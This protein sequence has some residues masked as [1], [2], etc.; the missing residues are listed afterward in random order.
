VGVKMTNAPIY[1]L[2]FN[3][4]IENIVD[5]YITHDSD[6]LTPNLHQTQ[7][8]QHKKEPYEN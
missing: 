6:K 4:A 7:T 3:N 8:H 1:S 2:H 5:K